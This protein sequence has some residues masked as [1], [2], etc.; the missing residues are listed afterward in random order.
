MIANINYY[1]HYVGENV[2]ESAISEW[3]EIIGGQL[4]NQLK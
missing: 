4:S 1:I 3:D 2:I